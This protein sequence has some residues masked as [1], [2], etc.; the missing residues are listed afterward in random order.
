MTGFLHFHNLHAGQTA[1]LVGNGP[2][3]QLTPPE[4]FNY[5][6]FGMNTIHLYE[7]WKPTYYAA[8]DKRVWREFGEAIAEK[9]RDIPKFVPAPKL[10][11]WQGEN[12][13][14]FVT[15]SGSMIVPQKPPNAAVSMT[16]YGIAYSNVMN[17]AMQLAWYMGFTTLLM[18]GV[19]HRLGEMRQHFWG[20]DTGM[21]IN[22]NI[23]ERRE[24]WMDSYRVL[25]DAMKGVRVL[26][27][28][29]DTYVPDDVLPRGDWQD[30][31]TK[32]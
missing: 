1:L 28:S 8:V 15:R 18:I 13:Y 2:N 17:V 11:S 12:F 4:R 31:I 21:S 5:P 22:S 27:I 24:A 26:N 25:C 20:E 19:Q 30:W 16:N 9:Y 29:R 32:N 6:S 14:R 23:P 7:G 10:D 3:L